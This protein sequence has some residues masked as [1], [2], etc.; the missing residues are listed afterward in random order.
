[1]K[2]P[3]QYPMDGPTRDIQRKM[4]SPIANR[5]ELEAYAN[6]HP[7]MRRETLDA[8]RIGNLTKRQP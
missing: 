3:K 6:N 8:C 5:A 2:R 7:N 1:M 4:E